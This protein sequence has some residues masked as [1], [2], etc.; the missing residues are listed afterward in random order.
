MRFT[1]ILPFLLGALSIAAQDVHKRDDSFVTTQGG[2]FYVNG[3]VFNF[4]GTN[5]YWL[6][7]LTEDKDIEN[8]FSSMAAAGIKVV[9]TW[10][11]N[12]V[13]EVPTSGIWFQLIADG[14]TRINNGTDG[15]ARLDKVVEV[16]QAHGIYLIFSL[17]NN[18]N[19]LPGDATVSRRDSITG[20]TLPRNY[21][22]NDFGG[23]DAYV[24]EFGTTKSHGEFYTDSSIVN[25]FN[26]YITTVVSR[27]VDCPAVLAWEIGND[28]RCI[29][30]LPT[31]NCTPQIVTQ[32]HS[33]V[34]Q[35]IKSIDTNHIISSGSGGFFCT[36][37]PKL[38]PAA[39]TCGGP[40][41]S[42]TNSSSWSAYNGSQ[43]VDSEDILGIPEI[44]YSS[45][46]MFTDQ[47]T[48]GSGVADPDIP[49]YNQTLATGV[50]W[51]NQH[52]AA[53]A[54]YCKPSV[55]TGFSLVTTG[56]APN[57]VPFNA[58]EVGAITGCVSDDQRDGA[59]GLWFG[60]AISSKVNGM[61]QYQWG[62]TG[63]TLTPA[64][65]SGLHTDLVLLDAE[66]T[67]DSPNDGSTTNGA[68]Q[69]GLNAIM[70]T[71]AQGAD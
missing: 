46:Q 4:I 61:V 35:H 56:N 50:N 63:L 30:S 5:A 53:A 36:G 19:P 70:R 66:D 59:Y 1:S 14:T 68:G 52:A 43:G 24:R 31:G 9:R 17:T 18:W 7:T 6:P 2:D 16:A 58:A 29:S 64:S 37:C 8:T 23:M 11:F 51:I 21:L 26:S 47:D 49:Q 44:G 32:W 22:S 45:F 48:Y 62:Q 33:T 20:N 3:S 40:S 28:P 65:P 34:A 10:A 39:A 55:A 54:A 27:Y 67:G 57:Y 38:F 15:L 13:T 25:T 41:D 60:T 12:D 42:G 71:A 69:S